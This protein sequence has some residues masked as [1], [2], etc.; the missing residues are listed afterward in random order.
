MGRAYILTGGT[1]AYS[2][3][4]ELCKSRDRQVIRSV[5]WA[6]GFNQISALLVIGLVV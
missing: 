6:G 3:P 5:G 2:E 1:V 4:V